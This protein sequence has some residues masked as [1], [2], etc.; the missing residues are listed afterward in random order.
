MGNSRK[1]QGGVKVVLKPLIN[2][3]EVAT[4]FC[5]AYTQSSS[6]EYGPEQF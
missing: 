1:R 6:K 2:L 3:L 5:V 4:I